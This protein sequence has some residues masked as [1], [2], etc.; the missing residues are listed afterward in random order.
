MSGPPEKPKSPHSAIGARQGRITGRV[1][2][3]LAISI[4]L[5]LAGMAL[6]YLYVAW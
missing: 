5:A 1:F 6:S 2:V 4:V 3:V